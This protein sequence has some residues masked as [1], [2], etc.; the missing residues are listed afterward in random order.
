MITGAQ[1]VGVVLKQG[2]EGHM[3][4]T[5]EVTGSWIMTNFIICILHQ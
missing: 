2:A 1:R 5:E 4:K 3:F